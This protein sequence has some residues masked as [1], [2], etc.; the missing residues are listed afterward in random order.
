MGV[1]SVRP[2][3]CSLACLECPAK[4]ELI[5]EQ[6]ASNFTHDELRFH[7]PSNHLYTR[8]EAQIFD[9]WI[10]SGN[11]RVT[12]V[13]SREVGDCRSTKASGESEAETQAQ[14]SEMIAARN[15]SSRGAHRE[16]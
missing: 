7:H 6:I 11:T 16:V 2:L 4:S 8:H 13:R 9:G 12:L 5:F 1:H 14:A 3:P 15:A 10:L